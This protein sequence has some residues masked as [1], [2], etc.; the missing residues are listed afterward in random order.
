MSYLSC[1]GLLT[2]DPMPSHDSL[3]LP[4]YSVTKKKGEVYTNPGE[5]WVQK[6][7]KDPNK[8]VMPPKNLSQSTVISRVARPSSSV[9]DDQ[10]PVEAYILGRKEEACEN[11][12]MQCHSQ[13]R[14]AG[15]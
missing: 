1:R 11:M 7:I 6:Y 2:V 10:A 8:P 13:G 9:L 14:R 5:G 12:A 3:T 15:C 4:Q